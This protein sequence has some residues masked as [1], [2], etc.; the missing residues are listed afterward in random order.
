MYERPTEPQSIGGVLDSGFKLF[1]ASFSQVVGLAIVAGFMSQLPSV[2]VTLMMGE[3]GAPDSSSLLSVMLISL[4]IVM[5]VS[6]VF[7]AAI[8][9]RMHGAH[10]GRE[11]SM[12]DAFNMG[13]S[14]MLPLLGCMLLYGLAIGVGSILLLIPGIIL[15]LSLMFGPYILIIERGGVLESL[16]RSHNLVWGYWWRT[17][18]IILI[19]FF[20]VMVAYVLIGIVAAAAIIMEPESVTS[21]GY[22][23]VEALVAALLSGLITPLF[24]A[25]T[26]AAYYDLRLRRQGEDLAER[27]DA[28]PQTA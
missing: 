6:M 15:S 16:K 5:L 20:I 26:L 7:F 10:A 21:P 3:G 8:V 4:L 23:L 13:F 24:Y 1:R 18:G 28:A 12:G 17:S 22:T 19:A 14:C 2:M 27:I 25:M 9:S 11:V